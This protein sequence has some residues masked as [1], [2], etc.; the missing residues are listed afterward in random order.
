[1]GTKRLSREDAFILPV[2]L[3]QQYEA[4]IRLLHMLKRQ[5]A[6]RIY[7]ET[8]CRIIDEDIERNRDAIKELVSAVSVAQ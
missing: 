5:P 6:S 7:T 4:K 2:V 8:V 3:P 1:M